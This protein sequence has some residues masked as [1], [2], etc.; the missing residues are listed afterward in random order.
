MLS[1]PKNGV[2][3]RAKSP[4]WLLGKDPDWMW[5]SFH[6]WRPRLKRF[7]SALASLMFALLTSKVC[8]KV[9]IHQVQARFLIASIIK[10]RNNDIPLESGVCIKN[11]SFC[12]ALSVLKSD[13]ALSCVGVRNCTLATCTATQYLPKSGVPECLNEPCQYPTRTGREVAYTLL[14]ICKCF[15]EVLVVLPALGHILNDG[16]HS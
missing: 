1:N 16:G 2:G 9:P 3:K 14:W 15:I 12:P 4:P 8:V 11:T 10:A 5:I 6:L 13:T 7:P